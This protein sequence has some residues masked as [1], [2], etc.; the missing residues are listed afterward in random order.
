MENQVKKT[1]RARWLYIMPV[2]FMT[3]FFYFIDRNIIG[4]A[5]PGGLQSDLALNATMAGF[6][7]GVVSIG[8]LFL[9]M[10]AGQM[11]QKG[12]VKKF[13]GICI[14]GWSVFTFLTAFVQNGWQLIIIRFI[15]GLFEGAYSPGV[16]TLF[17]FWFPDKDGERNRANSTYFT[18][19]S[20]AI[21]GMGPIG[22]LLMQFFGWRQMFM[23]LGVL[24]ALTLILWQIFI[25]DRPGQAK[26]MSKEEVEYIETTIQQERELAKQVGG[27]VKVKSNGFPL[28]LLLR[29]KYVWSLLII[30]FT[31]NIGQFGFSM[32]MPTMIKN[33]TKGSISSV[34]FIS[35]IPNI[36][37]IISLWVWSSIA[38]KVKSRRL[39]S[40]L[41]LI[42]FGI[43]LTVGTLI[44]P[45]MSPVIQIGALCLV[46]VF[47]QGHMPSYFTIPSLVLVKELD[48]PCRGLMAFVM[49]FGSFVGPYAVGG[50]MSLTGSNAAGTYFMTAVLILGGLSAFMLPK[51]IGIKAEASKEE[52]SA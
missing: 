26:W 15:I 27:D 35:M 7:A 47:T 40:G 36:F 52:Q 16:T 12:N 46:A 21:V 50:L 29:N 28:G 10:P 41:P 30:G 14:A 37:T 34:G 9:T 4:L 17:T 18:G 6:V 44:D 8:I 3:T 13:L 1:P 38:I 48:G 45:N 39:T 32:W 51:N 43:A 5:L 2:V 19:L 49:G 22:G 24:S 23:V 33:I 31:V 25:Y 20:V 11:A 42:L